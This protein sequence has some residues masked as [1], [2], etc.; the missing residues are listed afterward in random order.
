M[1][2]D[3]RMSENSVTGITYGVVGCWFDG[4]EVAGGALPEEVDANE[5]TLQFW[6][7]IYND[8]SLLV[9]IKIPRRTGHREFGRI[10]RW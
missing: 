2:P 4:W 7:E 1:T 9:E 10:R 6:Q 8:Q 3:L 5:T